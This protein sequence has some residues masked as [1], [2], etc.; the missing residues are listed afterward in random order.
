MVKVCV[1]CSVAS[2]WTA[3]LV[4]GGEWVAEMGERERR[5]DEVSRAG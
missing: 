1:G 5:K 2:R 3:V 4:E